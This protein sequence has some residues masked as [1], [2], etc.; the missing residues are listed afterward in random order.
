MRSV[1]WCAGSISQD[2][3]QLRLVDP[4]R[5]RRHQSRPSVIVGELLA[6][7]KLPAPNY[8]QTVALVSHAVVGT[9]QPT[10]SE[11]LQD[12][13]FALHMRGV[14]DVIPNTSAEPPR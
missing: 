7:Q 12:T 2:L 9:P 14:E 6:R 3:P 1:S 4:C 8:V 11:A 13:R 5:R 10:D